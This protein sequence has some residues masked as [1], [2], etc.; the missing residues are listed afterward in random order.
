MLFRYLVA[1]GSVTIWK[2]IP[3]E[4]GGGRKTLVPSIGPGGFFGERS[5]LL[6]EKRFASVQALGDGAQLLKLLRSDFNIIL[7]PL[8]NLLKERVSNYNNPSAASTSVELVA[9]HKEVV[10]TL[11]DRSILYD[12][13][14]HITSI[15]QGAY[16]YVSLVRDKRTSNLYAMKAVSKAHI[17]ENNNQSHIIEERNALLRL[18]HQNIVKLHSTINRRDELCFLLEP[19]LGGE[20]YSVMKQ[21]KFLAEPTARFYAAQVVLALEH[22]HSKH[23]VYRDLKL[24]N[25]VLDSFGYLKIIDFGFVKKVT[26]KTYTLCGSPEYLAPEIVTNKGHNKAVDWWALGVLIH[27]M[28]SGLTP[29]FDEDYM[30]MYAKIA[31]GKFT[32]ARYLRESS[33]S[34]ITGFL[35]TNPTQR[36]GVS[37]DGVAQIKEHKWFSA[38]R[39]DRLKARE[40]PPPYTPTVDDKD[41]SHLEKIP[42]KN[43]TQKYIAK[44][45]DD[46][47]AAF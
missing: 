43:H 12:D 23:Y 19:C 24:E 14:E 44:V 8:E 30:R 25:L 38:M 20:L 21:F 13:L 35:A 33:K 39:W 36:L 27:E 34:I 1:K 42:E 16:G 45:N 17:V 15:G 41:F 26:S 11:L 47:D 7:G 31:K 40:L 22:I 18:A 5:L 32:L 3:E 10:E 6:G 2:A 9:E 37:R 28:L 46:W 4:A 29:F